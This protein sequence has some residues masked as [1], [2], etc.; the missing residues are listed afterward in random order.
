MGKFAINGAKF[1]LFSGLN[2]PYSANNLLAI[3]SI[4]IALNLV[5]ISS[6][7]YHE[8]EPQ[9]KKHQPRMQLVC[10]NRQKSVITQKLSTSKQPRR[11]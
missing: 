1:P 10:L 8:I 7:G 3:S 5:L 9:I 6:K 4:L 2:W 11:M